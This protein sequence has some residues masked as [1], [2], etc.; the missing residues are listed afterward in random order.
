LIERS[1]GF[2]SFATLFLLQC[3]LAIWLGFAIQR[4]PGFFS[5]AKTR[6]S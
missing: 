5:S 4:R 2:A 1:R 6:S 3:D